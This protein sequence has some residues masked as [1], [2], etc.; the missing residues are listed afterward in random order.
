MMQSLYTA[1]TGMAAQQL[2]IDTIANNLA[3]VSTTGFK[4]QRVDFQDLNVCE[5]ETSRYTDFTRN[6]HAHG[7]SNRRGC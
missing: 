4:S 3:N 1:A 6:K 5:F 7:Y 2:N